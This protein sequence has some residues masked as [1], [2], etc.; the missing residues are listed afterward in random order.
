M[1]K[2]LFALLAVTLVLVGCGQQRTEGDL[3][4]IVVDKYHVCTT[5]FDVLNCSHIIAVQFSESKAC[6]FAYGTPNPAVFNVGDKVIISSPKDSKE[7]ACVAKELTN[8]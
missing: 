4:G 3:N 2:L 5:N 7:R 1:K 6:I 8:N